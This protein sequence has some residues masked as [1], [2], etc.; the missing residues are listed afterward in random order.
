MCDNVSECREQEA[1]GQAPQLSLFCTCMGRAKGSR[2]SRRVKDDVQDYKLASGRKPVL[3]KEIKLIKTLAKR[4][5]PFR[6]K[7]IRLL[8]GKYAEANDLFQ[9]KK[10]G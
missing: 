2:G 8:A 7:E 10:R 9:E 4:G 3:P 6:R 5:F 1:A